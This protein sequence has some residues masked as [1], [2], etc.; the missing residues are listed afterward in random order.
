MESFG[1]ESMKQWETTF[2]ETTLYFTA[3]LTVLFAALS[4]KLTPHHQS[5]TSFL[6]PPPLLSDFAHQS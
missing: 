5:H 4:S 1:M 3:V 6:T 2:L